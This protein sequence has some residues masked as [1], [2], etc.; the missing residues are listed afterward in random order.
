MVQRRATTQEAARQRQ[1]SLMARI[2]ALSEQMGSE[3]LAARPLDGNLVEIR[4]RGDGPAALLDFER[5]VSRLEG[6]ARVSIHAIDH[7]Q[8]TFSV[9]LLRAP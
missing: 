6:V 4:L 1:R 8:A 9:E 7:R 5:G 2:K 3:L